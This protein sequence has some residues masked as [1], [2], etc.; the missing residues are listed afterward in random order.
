MAY[1]ASQLLFDILPR[2]G[3]AKPTGI[4]VFG[5]ANSITSIIFKK[6]LERNSDLLATGSLS[7]IIPAGQ[8]SFTLPTDFLSPAEKPYA[9]AVEGLVTSLTTQLTTAGLTG[10]NLTMINNLLASS[11][12]LVSN[13]QAIVTAQPLVANVQGIIDGLTASQQHQHLQPSYLNDDYD[14]NEYGWWEWYGLNGESWEPSGTL[15]HKMKIINTTM[16]IRPKVVWDISLKGRYF[17]QPARVTVPADVL[18]FNSLFD[19][20]YREGCVKIIV[21]G[22]A[23]PDADPTFLSFVHREVETV[24]NSRVHLT[25]NRRTN[26]STFL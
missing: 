5:A 12:T 14:H 18:P 6:L 17:Q 25:P 11:G 4:T 1:T 13:I 20:V 8:Y 16:F 9:V 2:V 24:V 3:N 10:P 26:R 19:E 22:M 23:M 7:A 15:P 21:E